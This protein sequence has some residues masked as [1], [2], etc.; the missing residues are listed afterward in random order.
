MCKKTMMLAF[1]LLTILG[2]SQFLAACHT[3]A[4]VGEDMSQAGQAIEKSANKH[5]P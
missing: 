5:A 1:A 2:T 4:G 3:T